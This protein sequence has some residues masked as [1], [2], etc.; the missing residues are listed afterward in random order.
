MKLWLDYTFAGHSCRLFFDGSMFV[1][2]LN[3][4]FI[5]DVHLGK[6]GQYRKEGIPTPIAVHKF[7]M[8]RIAAALD[9]HAKATV[10]FLGDL[11][12]G[13]QNK[14]TSELQ[15]LIKAHPQRTFILVKGNHDFD[16]PNW[17]ELSVR[18]EYQLG[19][20]L[21]LHEPPGSDFDKEISFDREKAYQQHPELRQGKVLLCG[22]LHPGASLK[23]KGRFRVKT[24]AFYFNQWIGILPA[25]GALTGHYSLGEKGTYF[26][27]AE[28]YIVPLGDWDK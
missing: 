26:G 9:R 11:F 4:L 28:N 3:T 16:L 6:G 19:N 8:K 7:G 18:N 22:H 15:T 14:E 27:I 17:P 21:C 23:G 20:F 12:E 10:V 24:K 5:S 25:F 2:E 1:E 13:A